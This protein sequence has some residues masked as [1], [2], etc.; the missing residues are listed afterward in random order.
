MLLPLLKS[1]HL[2]LF[3]KILR[4]S[5]IDVETIS[6]VYFEVYCEMQDTFLLISGGNFGSDNRFSKFY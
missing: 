2:W 6:I 5:D 4:V 3:G 1:W